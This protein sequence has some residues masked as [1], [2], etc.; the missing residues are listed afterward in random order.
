[1]ATDAI[2]GETVVVVRI[3]PRSLENAAETPVSRINRRIKELEGLLKAEELQL[4]Q[5]MD[6]CQ[7]QWRH[8]TDTPFEL[9]AEAVPNSSWRMADHRHSLNIGCEWCDMRHDNSS[10][11]W[12]CRACLKQIPVLTIPNRTRFWYDTGDE[13]RCTFERYLNGRLTYLIWHENER[14]RVPHC[15][16]C[17]LFDFVVD[18]SRRGEH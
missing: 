1:M 17:L 16:D 8:L 7:H 13:P 9:T 4:E 3:E 15:H 11:G 18:K 2:V 6:Q 12:L 10:D 14:M 5:A